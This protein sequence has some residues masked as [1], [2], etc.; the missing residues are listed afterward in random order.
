MLKVL[1]V[2]N[3]ASFF[4]S[5]FIQL[6]MKKSNEG[7]D[8]HLASGDNDLLD[9]YSGLGVKCHDLGFSRKGR[10]PF[11]ELIVLT[12]LFKLIRSLKPSHIHAFTIKPVLYLGIVNKLTQCS[13]INNCVFSITGL[14][15]LYLSE[16]LL[17]KI[18]KT[19]VFRLYKYCFSSRK[20]RVVFENEDDLTFFIS[21]G[22]C[23]KNKSF[24]V[25]GAG[26]DTGYYTPR[27]KSLTPIVVTFVGRLIK[28]KGI[29]EFIEVARRISHINEN[30]IFNIVGDIDENNPSSISHLELSKVKELPNIRVLGFKKDIKEIYQNTNI[31]CL[32]SYREGLPKSLIEACSC[33]IPIVTT[34][35]PGCRQIVNTG[36]ENGFLVSVKNVESLLKAI[37]D[38]SSDHERL[39]RFSKASREKAIEY[40]DYSVILDSFEKIYNS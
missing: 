1:F 7:Y 20:A 30:I 32:P 11:S 9:Y 26:I 28:D 23:D 37:L 2:V 25:N 8:V 38:L 39:I 4:K 16:N 19:I 12:K 6:A 15:S 18:A 24:L 35:V 14:G 10:N 5:H 34:D 13:S 22:I 33:G 40:Y 3:S 27:S 31:A 17:N 21:E 36:K 29:I